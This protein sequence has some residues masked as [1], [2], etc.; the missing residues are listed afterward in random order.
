MTSVGYA[1]KQHF[2]FFPSLTNLTTKMQ[3]NKLFIEL[4]VKIYCLSSIDFSKTLKIDLTLSFYGRAFS[5]FEKLA[6]NSFSLHI[7]VISCLTLT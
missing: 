3:K 2:Y 7:F 5:F 6:G 4:L 1:I